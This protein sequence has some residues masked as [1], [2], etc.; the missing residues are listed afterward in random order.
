LAFYFQI[1]DCIGLPVDKSVGI[2]VSKEQPPKFGIDVHTSPVGRSNTQ[3]KS[4]TDPFLSNV[5]SS[6][7]AIDGG[8]NCCAMV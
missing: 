3:A 2:T 6:S 7:Q 5:H 4:F 1:I 8:M